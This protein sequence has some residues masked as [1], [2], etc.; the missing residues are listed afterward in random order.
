MP[1]RTALKHE[2]GNGMDSQLVHD[3]RPMR[4]HSVQTQTE[5][6]GDFL[7]RPSLG[8]QVV[9]L[10]LTFREKLISI[11]ELLLIQAAAVGLLKQRAT[12]GLKNALPA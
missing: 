10:P 6:R 4:F 9:Q 5:A 3:P 11:I 7:V 12:E 2:F 8:E 1:R